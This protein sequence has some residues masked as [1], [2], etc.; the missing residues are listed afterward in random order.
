MPGTRKPPT[1]SAIVTRLLSRERGASISE[2]TKATGWQPHSVR[3]FLTAV[4]RKATLAK[5][6]RS[7]GVTAYRIAEIRQDEP[8]AGED[9]L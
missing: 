7:D 6:E 8:I 4:R 2:M 3:A 1:K 5:E 9:T